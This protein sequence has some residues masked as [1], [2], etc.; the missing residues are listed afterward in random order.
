M[1]T[2]TELI[3]TEEPG[4]ELIH[5]WIADAVR[6]VEI[7]PATSLEK[8]ETALLQLQITTR[9]P[10]GA[11]AYQTGGLLI[12]G[13]WVRVLGGSF[14][15]QSDTLPSIYEWNLNKTINDNNLPI[16][17]YVI[18]AID[19]LGGF[20]CINGGSLGDDVGNIYY[21]AQDTLNFEP[22]EISYSD[23]IY[24]FICGD[25]EQFYEGFKWST[26]QSDI[27][28]LRLNHVFSFFPFLWTEE[29]KNIE[30]TM[31]NPIPTEEQYQVDIMYRNGLNDIE[32]K[33]K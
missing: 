7:L 6:P 25:M 9:S 2:L 32:N 4:I 21:F 30:S 14:E 19:V 3:N 20:F 33:Y 22:L 1:R 8:A 11:I 26:W 24:F 29:G 13:G 31:R 17:R 27:F 5:E 10:M 18:V 28:A 16:V 15:D 12:D 23:L